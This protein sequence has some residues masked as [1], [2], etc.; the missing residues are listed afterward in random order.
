MTFR[1]ASA[2]LE[3]SAIPPD[4]RL[5]EAA[6]NMRTSRVV[7]VVNLIRS[8]AQLAEAIRLGWRRRG[9]PA[10]TVLSPSWRILVS[11]R[12]RVAQLGL[13]WLS[14]AT[15]RTRPR[16]VGPKIAGFSVVFNLIGARSAR[17]L[18]HPGI[19]RRGGYG[20]HAVTRAGSCGPPLPTRRPLRSR[21]SCR[22]AGR[23]RV[24]LS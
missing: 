21:A 13:V 22:V 20:G 12:R 10:A 3:A 16:V 9:K 6:V 5:A 7:K 11:L 4:R 17:R 1:G 18:R 15:L 24:P 14:L 8:P 23:R 2:V 19:A